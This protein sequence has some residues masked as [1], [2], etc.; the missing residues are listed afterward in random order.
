MFALL[1]FF[2]FGNEW[3]LAGWLPLF[4]VWR[5]GISPRR[6]LM[7]V[8]LYWLALLAGRA[9][10]VWIIGRVRSGRLLVSSVLA[11][12]FGLALLFLTDN[13]FGAGTGAMLAGA[14]FAGVYPIVAEM[15]G[16]RFP[17]YHPAFFNGIFSFA[18][19]GGMLAPATLGYF[20]AWAGIGVVM[21]LPLAGMCMVLVL[22]GLIWLETKVTGR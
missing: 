3:S 12:I 10:A 6:G 8:A 21:A 5:L 13:S 7:L 20:A 14:G 18:L 1:L 17:Y 9:A 19:I 22:L 2:Q 11:A 4:L 15:I 16:R